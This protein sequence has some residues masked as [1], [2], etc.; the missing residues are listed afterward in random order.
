[1]TRKAPE[2]TAARLKE[3]LPAADI[4]VAEPMEAHTT[5]RAGGKADLFVTVSGVADLCACIRLLKEAGVPFFFAGRGSNLLVSDKG[6]HGAII[7]PGGGCFQE[8]RIDGTRVTAGAAV[9]L[10]QAAQA[11]NEASLSGMEALSGIPGSIGGA[12]AMNAGAYG[13]EMKDVVTGVTALDLQLLS[14]VP[15]SGAED[16]ASATDAVIRLTGEEMRFGYRTSVA[17]T[18]PLVFLEAEL[19][20]TPGDR[21]EIRGRMQE[22]QK[23]RSTKQPL[24]YPSAGSTFKRPEGHFAGKLIEEA[25]L[26]GFTVGGAQVSEKHCGFIVNKGGATATDILTLMR[27]VRARVLETSGVPLEP[28][29]MILGEEL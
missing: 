24:E 20:L 23:Q 8:L 10:F 11:A 9:T 15:Q 17:K 13:T 6:W 4:R 3:L 19:S 25:G 2:A 1:M 7:R 27:H 12:L 26:R 21:E 28:E 29:V 22:L 16:D 18:R 5:F 14:G